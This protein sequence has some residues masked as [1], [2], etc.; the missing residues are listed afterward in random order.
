MPG[1]S[2]TGTCVWWGKGEG[3]EGGEGAGAG[4]D[5][6]WFKAWVG[7]GSMGLIEWQARGSCMSWVQQRMCG[8][9]GW[10]QNEGGDGAG[11]RAP[12]DAALVTECIFHPMPKGAQ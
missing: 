12:V 1:G 3:G 8:V 5:Q 7:H 9:G 2:F 6:L 11:A 4:Q 10:G